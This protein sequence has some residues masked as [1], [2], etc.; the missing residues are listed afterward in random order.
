[1]KD[2]VRFIPKLVNLVVLDH[3]V[4]SRVGASAELHADSSG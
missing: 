3:A 1:L 2:H 4:N